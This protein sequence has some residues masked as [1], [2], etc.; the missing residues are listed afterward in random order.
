MHCF[1]FVRKTLGLKLIQKLIWDQTVMVTWLDCKALKEQMF[2]LDRVSHPDWISY[3]FIKTTTS[4]LISLELL[5]VREHGEP[6]KDDITEKYKND[7]LA[8]HNHFKTRNKSTVI[9][10]A[11]LSPFP[12][13]FPRWSRSQPPPHL[14]VVSPRITRWR[15]ITVVH[16]LLSVCLH[17]CLSVDDRACLS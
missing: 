11:C 5:L 12:L 8:A 2:N 7:S 6:V 16:I 4:E 3:F 17:S 14:E 13:H 1:G 9:F 15:K 10:K